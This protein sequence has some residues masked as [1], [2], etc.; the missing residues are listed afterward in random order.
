MV[1]TKTFEE[2]KQLQILHGYVLTI[3]RFEEIVENGIKKIKIT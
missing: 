1:N 2:E 3:V